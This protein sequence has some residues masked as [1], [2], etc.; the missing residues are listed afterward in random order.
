MTRLDLIGGMSLA[1]A[2]LAAPILWAEEIPAAIG[3]ISYGVEPVPGTAICTGV[4]VAPRLVLTAA[5]CVRGAEV[6][7]DDIRFD[8]GWSEGRPAIRRRGAEVILA[9]AGGAPGLAGLGEDVA[10][11]T[12][13]ADLP[14]EAYA[15]LSLTDPEAGPF[16]LI[17]FD[18][19]APD[20][21]R[22]A[23]L[24]RPLAR[25]PDLLA[26]D[27]PVVSGNSGAP[28]LQRDGDGWRVVA[29]MVAS[30]QGRPI[31]SWAAVPPVPLRLRI[32]D[33]EAAGN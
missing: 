9:G 28:L 31:R 12:L 6:T 1:M 30:A 18:R 24:C 19:T 7:P 4:L 16:T 14:I 25:R 11:V 8:A 26:L 5:H 22:P 20:R 17:A 10:L 21:P 15:P 27:C 23:L 2:L 32:S 3:R 29:V 33:A 13:D